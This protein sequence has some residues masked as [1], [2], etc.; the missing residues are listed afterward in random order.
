MFHHIL[1]LLHRDRICVQLEQSSKYDCVGFLTGYWYFTYFVLKIGTPE[2]LFKILQLLNVC[3][4]RIKLLLGKLQSL[5]APKI[6]IFN[7]V[8][9]GLSLQTLL[10]AASQHFI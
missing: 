4:K 2:R 5:W 3:K 7:L 1:R 10:Q 8:Y 6:Y 9:V